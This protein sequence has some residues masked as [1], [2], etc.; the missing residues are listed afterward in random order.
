MTHS[1]SSRVHNEL[2]LI[3]IS[4]RASALSPSFRPGID[5]DALIEQLRNPPG[6]ARAAICN[7]TGR[8]WGYGVK[9]PSDIHKRNEKKAYVHV[10]WSTGQFAAIAATDSE[11]QPNFGFCNNPHAIPSLEKRKD[12]E[13]LPDTYFVV[14]STFAH[15]CPM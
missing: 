12:A 2:L 6:H 11:L 1:L 8:L 7:Q 9:D 10:P 5:L 4:M 13:F 3:Q 15:A 14:S